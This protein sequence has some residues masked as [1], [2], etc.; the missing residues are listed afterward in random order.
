MGQLVSSLL[1]DLNV[2]VDNATAI[3]APTTKLRELLI[4]QL[5]TVCQGRLGSDAQA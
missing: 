1:T 4:T 3:T 5:V 2:P